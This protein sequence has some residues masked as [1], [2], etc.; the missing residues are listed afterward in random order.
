MHEEWNQEPQHVVRWWVAGPSGPSGL[1]ETKIQQ[2]H[3]FLN[4]P[5][6]FARAPA[7]AGS[8]QQKLYRS[9]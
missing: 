3:I 7:F 5:K 9:A 6:V 4:G 1:W 2:L 8:N